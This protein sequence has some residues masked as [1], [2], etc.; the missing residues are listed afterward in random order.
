MNEIS[1][2]RRYTRWLPY[3]VILV[4]MLLVPAVVS[5][6]QL[7]LP[8]EVFLF[9][10]FALTYDL[11]F[12][13]TGLISFGHA[14][15]VGTGAYALAIAT[16]THHAPLWL[17][18]LIV[19]TAGLVM[20]LVSG[21]LA[22]RT[23][24]VYFAMVTL[25]FSQ[26]AFT[27]AQSDIAGLTGGENGMLITGAPDWLSGPGSGQHFYYVALATLVLCF[28]LLRLFVHS[29]AGTV[30]QA[31]RENE[32]RAMMLGYR[33]YRYKLLAYVISGTVATAAGGLYAVFVGAISPN[34]FAADTTINLLL[35]VI[36]GGAG[37]LWG[38]VVGAAI[39]RALNQYLNQLSTS[40]FVSG[41]PS[42]LH[43][44]L[45]QPLLIFGVIYLLLVFFFPEGI[46]GL[47]QRRRHHIPTA[48]LPGLD[49]LQQPAPI[50]ASAPV[51]GA[52]RG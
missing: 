36:I 22:L 43:Q 44:T 27:L 50:D 4:V 51:E 34:L 45:G 38:A 10:L 14:L 26:A 23:S 19:L 32:Q 42:W 48:P 39:I 33:P 49:S 35:M 18:F 15:F 21:A 47:A 40:A 13:Y 11:I 12:G 17:A 41:L 28:L 3:A 8:T 1:L 46:A 30:W 7:R 16:T 52:R 2:G 9:A 25:A 5:A 6:S 31:V 29:P 20:S 24:G 37:S